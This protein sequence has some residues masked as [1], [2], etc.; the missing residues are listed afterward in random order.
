MMSVFLVILFSLIVSS[1]TSILILKRIKHKQWSMFTALIMNIILLIGAFCILVSL[2][3]EAKMFGLG[4]TNLYL[5]VLAIP[6][7]SWFSFMILIS[8]Q[9]KLLNQ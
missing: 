5:L 6:I 7:N 8:C 9:K 3:Q 4:N 1:L 2:N